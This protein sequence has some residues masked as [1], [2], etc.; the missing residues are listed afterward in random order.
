MIRNQIV[1]MLHRLLPVAVLAVL[2]VSAVAPLLATPQT[3]AAAPAVDWVRQFGTAEYD[4]V[5][6][7][8]VGSSGVYVVGLLGGDGFLRK[9]TSGGSLVWTRDLGYIDHSCVAV[10]YG[11]IY[12][13]YGSG[14]SG[15]LRK[16][17]SSGSVLWSRTLSNADYYYLPTC[18]TTY[19]SSIYVGGTIWSTSSGDV[20]GE[21]VRKYSYSGTKVWNRLLPNIWDDQGCLGVSACS[22][23]IYLLVHHFGETQ[24]NSGDFLHKYSSGGSLVWTRHV[25][26]Y[27]GHHCSAV[28]AN[29]SAIYL[30]GYT[31]NGMFVGKYT[32]SGVM[33]WEK[34]T[35]VAYA[36]TAFA[37]SGGV[38]VTGTVCGV[39]AG[40][41]N[42]GG[43]D[44]FVRKY[45]TGGNVS[46]TRQLGTSDTDDGLAVSGTATR[47]YLGGWTSG[48][49]PGYSNQGNFDVFLLR[50]TLA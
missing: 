1:H 35:N 37:F 29:G 25:A 8:S 2:L 9:Y 7:L 44:A 38:Y 47:I 32:S 39:L 22:S 43:C 40:Q 31:A 20:C 30:V 13:G 49:F 14:V 36:Q 26:V 5:F 4:T 41:T 48:A 33:A 18:I 23:G 19:S 12:V 45:D 34:T 50:M 28:S 46:W 3:A 27:T 15:Y 21:F 6:S 24:A 10:G 17:S 11:G 42:Q 16:Y